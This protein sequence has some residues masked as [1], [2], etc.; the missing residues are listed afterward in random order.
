MAR[1]CTVQYTIDWIRNMS[2]WVPDLTKRSD[3][4]EYSLDEL[5]L[6]MHGVDPK[7]AHEYTEAEPGFNNIGRA[8]DV[9]RH[10]KLLEAGVMAGRLSYSQGI[11]GNC[12]Y[13]NKAQ[14]LP[15][16][17]EKGYTELADG[18]SIRPSGGIQPIKPLQASAAQRAA[19]LVA[20][21]QLGYDPE[22]LPKAPKGMTGVKK[23]VR[24]LVDGQPPFTASSSFDKIWQQ[25]RQDGDIAD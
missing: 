2:R 10:K 14:L 11:S 13:I 19:I 12:L 9:T 6:L 25:M 21:Q 1:R 18:L 4:D 16:L 17:H 22:N 7:F 24:D 5:A 15:W 20:I 3:F 23:Q 8:A